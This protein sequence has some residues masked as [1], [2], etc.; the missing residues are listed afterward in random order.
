MPPQ[1]LRTYRQA[2]SRYHLHPEAK[3]HGGDYTDSG[4]LYRRHIRVP[5]TDGIRHIGKEANRWE[6][7][8][9]TGEDPEAEIRYGAS[10]GSLAE[11]QARVAAACTEYGVRAVAR[12]AELAHSAVLRFVKAAGE[13]EPGTVQRLRGALAQLESEGTEADAVLARARELREQVGLHQLAARTGIDRANLRAVL[14]GKR[15]PSPAMLA[16]L[17]AECWAD[18][19]EAAT[20][21]A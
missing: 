11:L 6:E 21:R 13:P 10:G 12:A 17:K 1:L 4:V 14:S 16:R 7:R 2:V 20:T 5:D 18:R 9:K 15:R 8:S 3:F 19:R